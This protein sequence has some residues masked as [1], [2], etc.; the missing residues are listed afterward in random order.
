PVIIGGG[1][2]NAF[3]NIKG[4]AEASGKAINVLNIDAHTDLRKL[5]HRHS[6]NGFSYALQNG[7]LE[8]YSVFG[9]H[10][11]YTPQYIFEEM[12]ASEAMQ[13]RLLEE[14]PQQN[15][16]EEF[17]QALDFVKEETFGLELDCDAIANF[18]SSAISPAGFNLE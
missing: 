2:N 12:H 16:R 8:K 14:L 5:E 18:P 13:Y 4:A 1:H 10:K 11:N 3:G 15:R 6:G 7:F 17:Q 9:L